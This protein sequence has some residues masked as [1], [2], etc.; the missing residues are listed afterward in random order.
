MGCEN[1]SPNPSAKMIND[2][3]KRKVPDNVSI[4]D[5]IMPWKNEIKQQKVTETTGMAKVVK[6]RSKVENMDFSKEAF[7]VQAILVNPPWDCCKPIGASSKQKTV[8][9]KDFSENFKID[10][11]VMK[12]GLVFIWVEKEYI[13]DII[14]CFEK[15]DFNYVE[16]VCYIM[17]DQ[18]KKAQVDATRE[19][20]ITDSYVYETGQY[21]RKTKKTLLIFRR[22]SQK[23]A[24]CTLEL[25]HQRTCD[26][27]FDW[28]KSEA[29]LKQNPEKA[30]PIN[31]DGIKRTD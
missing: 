8:S 4:F 19:I 23:K 21:L 31:H 20:H 12:D 14:K 13:S 24:K 5:L 6:T 2:D 22:V 30:D 7:D 11:H 29:S 9:I 27:C 28:A 26:V 17:L 1:K 16:N 25:R 15:Q 10:T 3:G 18:T